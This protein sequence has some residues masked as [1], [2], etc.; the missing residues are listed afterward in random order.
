[1]SVVHGQL[2]V[3][4]VSSRIQTTDDGQLTTDKKFSFSEDF[5]LD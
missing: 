4:V 1:M 2:P 5:C 3:V